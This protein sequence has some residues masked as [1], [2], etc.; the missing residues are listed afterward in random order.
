M[1]M[2]EYAINV[3]T[4][5]IDNYMRKRNNKI[6]H[7]RYI[8]NVKAPYNIR[9]LALN[10]NRCVPKDD[11]KIQMLINGCKKHNIDIIL[12]NE[13]NTKQN[14]PNRDRIERKLK[15]LGREV[16]IAIV[17]STLQNTTNHDWLPG[18]LMTAVRRKSTSLINEDQAKKG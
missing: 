2:P 4:V 13:M 11:S 9:I 1:N 8:D 5:T 3:Q 7:K 16:F 6:M 15:V 17:D 12:L 18:G 10:L 14:A